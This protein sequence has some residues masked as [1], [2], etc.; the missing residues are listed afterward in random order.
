MTAPDVR[1]LLCRLITRP[2]ETAGRLS[3]PEWEAVIPAAR[4]TRLI[5][6]IAVRV[7]ETPGGLAAVPSGPRRHLEAARLAADRHRHDVLAEVERVLEAL[8]PLGITPMLL[9]G[10]AYAVGGAAAADGR[11]FGDIDLMV[12]RDR[13]AEV[14]QALRRAGWASS[15][16]DPYDFLYYHRWMHQLPPLVHMERQSVLDVHHTLTAPVSRMAVDEAMVL[17]AGR[18]VMAGRA[19]VPMPADMVLHS[20]AHLF[21]DTEFPNGLRDLSDMD[22]LM[23][24]Q[25][26]AASWWELLALRARNLGL[27][28]PLMM[29]FL[30]CRHLFET[31]VP[32]YVLARTAKDA[33]RRRVRRP[34]IDRLFDHAL[35]PDLPGCRTAFTGTA[36][37]AL[38]LRGHLLRMPP[39][40]LV[41]HLARKGFRAA[42]DWIK[43]D[44]PGRR[45]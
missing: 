41:P 14:D 2:G 40:L 24:A 31:P 33:G 18:R 44:P 34:V 42:T 8:A 38:H 13:L 12:P 25:G 26:D 3:L 39:A 5:A 6:R 37:R 10:A 35:R 29:A 7:D 27:S 11:L 1:A 22:R 30:H 4:A 15:K 17:A 21:T 20:A 23:R 45:A 9:K 32:D 43:A 16:L 19:L 36:T 28:E